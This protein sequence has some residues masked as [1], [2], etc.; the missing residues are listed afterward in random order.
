MPD[1][2]TALIAIRHAHLEEIRALE[3]DMEKIRTIL[4]KAHEVTAQKTVLP[5]WEIRT[6]LEEIAAV[7]KDT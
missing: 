5:A 7:L 6:L 4:K 1:F 2:N 3:K